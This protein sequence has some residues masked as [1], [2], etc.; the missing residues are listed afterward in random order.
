LSELDARLAEF[1]DQAART[2]FDYGAWDCCLWVADWIQLRRGVDP[3]A[4]LRGRYASALGCA[5]VLKR[6]GG[7]EAVFGACVTA[8]GLAPTCAWRAGD[9][10]VVE[11]HTLKGPE[12]VGAICTGPRWAVL[13]CPGILVAPFR[14]LAAWE[15]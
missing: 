12:P 7:V 2:P 8:A 11:A 6:G 10:G 3:A 15:I 1:L 14:P 9:V 4:H 5:R 13:A